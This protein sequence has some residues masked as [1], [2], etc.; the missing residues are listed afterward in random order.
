LCVG[1]DPDGDQQGSDCE[2]AGRT[3][4]LAKA[5]AKILQEGRQVSFFLVDR[6]DSQY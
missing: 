5:I 1:S 3:P 4:E 6:D 2:K